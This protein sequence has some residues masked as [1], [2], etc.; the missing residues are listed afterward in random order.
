MTKMTRIEYATT[1]PMS[2][3]QP[4]SPL[5]PARSWRIL[6]G[7]AMQGPFPPLACHRTDG[8]V[9]WTN[10]NCSESSVTRYQR[11]MKPSLGL[12]RPPLFGNLQL[13]KQ[14]ILDRQSTLLGSARRYST[15]SQ[16]RVRVHAKICSLATRSR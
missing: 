5:Q 1:H 13:P 14:L 12:G 16:N 6:L 15:A 9:L 11:T 2:E 10:P 8:Q 4:V 3:A 7:V